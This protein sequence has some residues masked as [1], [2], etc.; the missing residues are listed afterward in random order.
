MSPAIS[1]I[2][3]YENYVEQF[4]DLHFSMEQLDDDKTF[5]DIVGRIMKNN[6]LVQEAFKRC[7]EFVYA[8]T[9]HID[10]EGNFT[11]NK[12]YIHAPS[13]ISSFLTS[14]VMCRYH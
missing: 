10:A 2:T 4:S 7:P 12:S 1:V 13:P 8:Y 6:M 14:L 11:G 5:Q 3:E 9:R